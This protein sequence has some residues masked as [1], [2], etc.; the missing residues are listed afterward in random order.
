MKMVNAK[1]IEEN[2]ECIVDISDY[3]MSMKSVS[4]RVLILHLYLYIFI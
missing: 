2:E 3:N 1:F 4:L